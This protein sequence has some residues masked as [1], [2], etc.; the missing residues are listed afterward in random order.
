MARE[1]QMV[2][3]ATRIP[4]WLHRAV[5][6]H[7]AAG[8]KTIEQVVT[9]ALAKHLPTKLKVGEFADELRTRRKAAP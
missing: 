6:T 2:L 4:R 8:G 1:T 9:D 7:A 3:L 5:K